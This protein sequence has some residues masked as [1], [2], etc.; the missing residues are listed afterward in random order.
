MVDTTQTGQ[1]EAPVVKAWVQRLYML[2]KPQFRS[3]K[4]LCDPAHHRVGKCWNCGDGGW[5]ISD[6]RCI[7]PYDVRLCRRCLADVPE[8]QLVLLHELIGES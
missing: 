3:N 6:T 2:P 4:V 8:A 7:Y 1:E 5:S